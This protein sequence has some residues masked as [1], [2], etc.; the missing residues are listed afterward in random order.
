MNSVID[1][2]K[3]KS[4]LDTTDSVTTTTTTGNNSCSNNNSSSSS[5]SENRSQRRYDSG[6]LDGGSM[7]SVVVS[8]TPTNVIK[9]RGIGHEKTKLKSIGGHSIKLLTFFDLRAWA[10]KQMMTIR[11]LGTNCNVSCDI[12]LAKENH[13]TYGPYKVPTSRPRPSLSLS[14]KSSS[15]ML[16]SS[17]I[18]KRS[19][20]RNKKSGN[21]ETK[22][23][24]QDEDSFFTTNQ[25]KRNNHRTNQRLPWHTH[26]HQKWSSTTRHDLCVFV[27]VFSELAR[28]TTATSASTTL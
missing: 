28:E 20:S 4:K 2:L 19:R 17:T 15:S 11:N 10:P 12:L 22:I 13:D 16:S 3:S 26:K 25:N 9:M 1:S 5:N 6:K 27:E 21:E 7:T 24:Q 8:L 18:A 23:Q 14:S